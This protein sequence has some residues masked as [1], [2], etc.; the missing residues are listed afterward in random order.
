[1]FQVDDLVL[2][3][4][5]TSYTSPTSGETFAAGDVLRVAF[6][7]TSPFLGA[8]VGVDHGRGCYAVW[9]V[10]ADTLELVSKAAA[11]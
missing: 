11:R 10:M 8:I 5:T 1:M 7:R 4:G 9:S 3:Q 6:V 2:Y